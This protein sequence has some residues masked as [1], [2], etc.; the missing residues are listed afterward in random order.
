MECADTNQDFIG[1][2]TTA[3]VLM[4]PLRTKESECQVETRKARRKGETLLTQWSQQA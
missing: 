4:S 1:L 3:A 2:T